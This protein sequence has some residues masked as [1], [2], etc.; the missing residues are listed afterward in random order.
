MAL[1]SISEKRLVL[2]TGAGAS[3]N[4]GKTPIALMTDW[5]GRLARKLNK[6]ETGLASR[7]GLDDSSISPEDFEEALG[8][9][10]QWANDGIDL[11]KRFSE[12]GRFQVTDP[13]KS[14]VSVERP[15]RATNEKRTIDKWLTANADETRKAIDVMRTSMYEEFGQ[16]KI[17]P[18]KSAAAYGRLFEQLGVEV[19]DIVCAT[20]NYD[21]SLE[22]G[23]LEM[24]WPPADGF[25]GHPYRT[26]VLNVNSIVDWPKRH[27]ARVPVL[28]LHG[29]VGWYRRPDSTIT[30]QPP[31]QGYNRTL[32]LPVFL[33]PDPNK[34]PSN[35][36]NVAAIWDQFQRALQGAT[37]VVI[38]GHSLND[39]PLVKAVASSAP[40]AR[41]LIATLNPNVE[42]LVERLPRSQAVDFEFGPDYPSDSAEVWATGDASS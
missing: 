35:D 33:P 5:A 18:K 3:R 19:G 28:H 36:A 34:D 20:T 17:D 15:S 30:R 42:L 4:L 1:E 21:C 7:L 23:L 22:L 41:T 24:D 29:A 16:Q 8:A 26:P 40:Q 31:D 2:V 12:V 11:A 14:Q 27:H 25:E 32:G 38:L 10:V 37:H 9:F 39:Q 13:R 6:A